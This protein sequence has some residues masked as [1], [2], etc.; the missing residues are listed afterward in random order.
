MSYATMG[1][2]LNN[3]VIFI[4]ESVQELFAVGINE[5][6]PYLAWTIGVL[7]GGFLS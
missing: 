7:P 2:V 3:I 6:A 4:D 1:N 5:S